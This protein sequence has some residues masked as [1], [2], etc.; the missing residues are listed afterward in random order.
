MKYPLPDEKLKLAFVVPFGTHFD[1]LTVQTRALGGTEAA[2]VH[3]AKNLAEIGFDVTVFNRCDIE[4]CSAGT[5]YGVRYRPFEEVKDAKYFDIVISVQSLIPFVPPEYYDRI[6]PQDFDA[7]IFD[8]IRTTTR[9]KVVA[10]HNTSLGDVEDPLLEPMLVEG[11]IDRIFT[12]SDFQTI[13]LL[14]CSHHGAPK[15]NF[16]V[17]KNKVWQTRGGCDYDSSVHSGIELKDPDLFVSTSSVFKGLQNLI[18]QVWPKIKERIPN[19]RLDVLGGYYHTKPNDPDPN[20][21][22]WDKMVPFGTRYGAMFYGLLP[23][24]L[25]VSHL[26]KASFLLAPSAYPE[27][28]GLSLLEAQVYNTPVITCRFGAAEETAVDE[29]SYKIDYPI[30]ANNVYPNINNKEQVEK[31]VSAV[32][33]AHSD[34]TVWRAK[35]LYGNTIREVAGWSTIALQWKQHFHKVLDIYL[36]SADYFKVKT[37]NHTVHRV[38][39][40]RFMNPEE[41]I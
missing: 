39:R 2:V 13:Y 30:E 11:H 40:R 23:H 16:E 4:D 22:L 14:N 38:F 41:M 24:K 10:V 26:A 35:S 27:T 31:Y 32:V 28:F 1:G 7:S 19:A 5:F 8:N 9:Y 15:R 37:L 6:P 33:R 12:Q 18:Y 20:K 29:A 36:P 3:M 34:R 17:L 21:E 25:L